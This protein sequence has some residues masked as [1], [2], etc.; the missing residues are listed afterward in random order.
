MKLIEKLAIEAAKEWENTGCVIHES[1]E[2]AFKAGLE[3][4]FDDG[5]KKAREMAVAEICAIQFECFGVV[6]QREVI[7]VK[8]N[9]KKLGEEEVE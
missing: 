1:I 3:Y 5:F 8:E 7:S 6:D 4:G 9:I 2:Y